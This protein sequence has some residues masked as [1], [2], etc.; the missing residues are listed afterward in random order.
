M[1]EIYNASETSEKKDLNEKKHKRVSVSQIKKVIGRNGR[2]GIF[3]CFVTF[4]EH[5]K[6][7]AQEPGEE[8]ILFLRQ[9]P[10]VNLGWFLIVLI[11]L[12]LPSL[13]VFM[14]F[15][16]ALP[17]DYQAVIIMMWY[18][19]VFGYATAK[20]MGWFFNVFIVTDERLIDADFETLFTRII[21]ETKIERV[22][23][24]SAEMSGAFRLLFDYGTVT[25]QTAG[26][27]PEFD[28]ENVPKP[29]LVAKYISQ[30]VDLEEQEKLEGRVK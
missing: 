18:M 12:F 7:K 23:D 27:T 19:M 11:L 16:S 6:M 26:E 29:D 22:Q 1:V 10:I 8:I 9:H 25:F 21:S 28:F 15:Y 13:F 20:F 30:L 4:P 14:P 24:L 5:V 3:T 17:G 2:E